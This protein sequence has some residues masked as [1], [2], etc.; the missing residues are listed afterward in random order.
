MKVLFMI[1]KGR[2]F[3]IRRG[4]ER[5]RRRSKLEYIYAVGATYRSA[6]ANRL[7]LELILQ[8]LKRKI[9]NLTGSSSRIEYLP[10]PMDDPKRRRPDISLAREKLE[11]S[12]V[13]DMDEGLKRTI[14]YF[15]ELIR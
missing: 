13:I 7:T 12:P 6:K 2:R 10:L 1:Y 9:I 15:K 11:W 5:E 4:L 14:D 3:G 8:W